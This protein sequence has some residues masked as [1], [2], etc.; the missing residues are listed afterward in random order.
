MDP[1]ALGDQFGVD[2]AGQTLWMHFGEL[3]GTTVVG[4]LI[5]LIPVRVS[6]NWDSIVLHFDLTF[7]QR[8]HLDFSQTTAEL[9]VGDGEKPEVFAST[10]SRSDEALVFPFPVHEP[11]HMRLWIDGILNDGRPLPRRSVDLELRRSNSLDIS[12]WSSSTK[13]NCQNKIAK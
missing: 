12:I 2:F 8:T 9:E 4:P 11:V 1:R 7:S 6:P 13:W 5:P 10:H 3:R